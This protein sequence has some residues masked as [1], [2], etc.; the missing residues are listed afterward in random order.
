MLLK[1][2]VAIVTGAASGIGKA[3]ALTFGREGAKVMCADVNGDGAEAVARTIAD[4]GG[5]AASIKTDVIVE[6]DVKEMIAATVTRWGRLDVIVQQRGHRRRQPGDAGVDRGVGPDHR[7]QPAR[8]LPGHEAR[9]HGDAEDGRRRHRQ[10]GLGRR[11]HGHADAVRLLRV[12]GR[13][14]DV[15]EGD[16]GG[17]GAH[18]HPHQLRLP[19][20]DPTPI[21]DPM[22]QMAKAAGASARSSCGRAWAR[23]TRSVGW[24]TRKR[25]RRRWPGWPATARR[26]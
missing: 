14:R 24:A 9:D 13:R 21:L 2:K 4:T 10:H 25:W 18:G 20:R 7:H 17:V 6:D 8:R 15:H 11:P 12:Q 23:R 5:E 26:S 19:G 16:G 3:T 1:D 22:V